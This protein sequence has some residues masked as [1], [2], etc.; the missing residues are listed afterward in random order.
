MSLATT[1]DVSARVGQSFT[2]T[3]LPR[4]LAFL[5][6]ATALVT[7]YCTGTWDRTNPPAAFKGVVC[8]EVIRWLSIAPG[9]VLERT[10]EMETQYGVA[11]SNQELSQ[12]AKNSLSK[13]RLKAATINI[14]EPD[15]PPE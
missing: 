6:D 10:G 7:D 4:V 5:D 13:Y 9:V 15:C 1:D 14:R 8:G 11:A 3:E 2:A 12:A